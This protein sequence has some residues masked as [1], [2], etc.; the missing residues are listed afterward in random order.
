MLSKIIKFFSRGD[1]SP[2][3]VK[4][5][6]VYRIA[7]CAHVDGPLCDMRTCGDT[8]QL[9]I[10]PW[11]VESENVDQHEE[12]KCD[13]RM[14]ESSAQPVSAPRCQTCGDWRSSKCK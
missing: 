7:G 14:D 3:P 1:V 5:C 11:K 8:V 12:Q 4:L 10:S 2:D 9:T 6:Q 13:I